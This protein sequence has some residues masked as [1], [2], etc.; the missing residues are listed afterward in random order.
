MYVKP[1]QKTT[2][3]GVDLPFE[4]L[5]MRG[6]KGFP[7]SQEGLVFVHKDNRVV[8]CRLTRVPIQLRATYVIRTDHRGEGW[9]IDQHDLG[10]LFTAITGPD[11]QDYFPTNK[12]AAAALVA[13][14]NKVA[15]STTI[16]G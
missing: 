3:L 12:A 2:K 4:V 11:R 10:S 6:R 8:N 1:S 5:D 13:H 14:L 9:R 15:T 16:N 7:Q